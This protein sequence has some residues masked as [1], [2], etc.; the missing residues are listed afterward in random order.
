MVWF[1]LRGLRRVEDAS[2]S[3]LD[4]RLEEGGESRMK[5]EKLL[6]HDVVTGMILGG[7]IGL[8][9]PLDAYKFILV[10]LAVVLGHKLVS[11]K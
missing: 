11:T 9:F 6:G 4:K 1:Q 5:L 2:L 7:L 8:Y 10:T 3:T